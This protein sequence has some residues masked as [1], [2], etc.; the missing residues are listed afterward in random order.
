MGF[1]K[2]V[3]K[4][5]LINTAVNA[6]TGKRRPPP[7]KKPDNNGCA[8]CLLIILGLLL[9][10]ALAQNPQIIF[11]IIILAAIMGI[12][13]LSGYVINELITKT[14]NYLAEKREE[15]EYALQREKINSEKQAQMKA[16]LERNAENQKWRGIQEIKEAYD[17]LKEVLKEKNRM[18]EIKTA[19]LLINNLLQLRDLAFA[20]KDQKALDNKKFDALKADIERLKKTDDPEYYL[21]LQR[22]REKIVQHDQVMT[23][24][25]EIAGE[26]DNFLVKF[27]LNTAAGESTE[28]Y[29][30]YAKLKKHT[31]ILIQNLKTLDK[32]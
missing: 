10:P 22:L 16:D 3:G 1:L 25:Q 26:V 30:A 7:E 24:F 15:K 21:P 6:L 17:A 19:D 31:E 32:I 18:N 2:E 14:Q 9:L 4:Q 8:G 11:A 12:L 23:N 29:E 28:D 20:R 13:F 5:I 27:R